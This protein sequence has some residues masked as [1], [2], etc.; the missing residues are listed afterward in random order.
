VRRLVR[1]VEEVGG[2]PEVVERQ[3]EEQRLARAPGGR[4]LADGG[5][6]VRALPDRVVEDGR[7]RGEPRDRQLLHVA[8]E[9]AAGEERARDLIEPDALARLVETLGGLHLSSLPT[10]STTLPCDRMLSDRRDR[11]HRGPADI[12]A[13]AGMSASLPPSPP[14][15]RADCGHDGCK[16]AARPRRCREMPSEAAKRRLVW[17]VAGA[18]R[19]F[20]LELA[21]QV[22]ARGDALV[23]TA[24]N[25]RPLESELAGS[26]SPLLA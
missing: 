24:R 16:L 9:G 13:R 23:A 2:L 17:F 3:L 14:S 20:G 12:P 11:G 6:V 18:S 22:L 15:P 8:G 21:R 4:L 7:V 10:W 5:V 19:G 26:G 1:G 25:P